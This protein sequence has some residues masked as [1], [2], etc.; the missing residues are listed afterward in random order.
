MIGQ[1]EIGDIGNEYGGL[2]VKEE[3]GS[4]FWCIEDC[5]NNFDWKEITKSL[6]DELMKHQDNIDGSYKTK[7]HSDENDCPNEKTGTPISHKGYLR[8][9]TNTH[10]Q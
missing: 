5:F 9:K 3:N 10:F 7:Y 2:E 8:S 6:Y 1:R 4:C